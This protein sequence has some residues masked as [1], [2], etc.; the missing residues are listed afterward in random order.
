MT[1]IATFLKPVPVASTAL[2][3][4]VTGAWLAWSPVA[5][6]DT[7]AAQPP[8]VVDLVAK[9]SPAVV[10]VLATQEASAGDDQG[11]GRRGLAVRPGFA[12]R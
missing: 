8:S 10:T 1:R 7:Q 12:F 3:A 11:G 2:A 4:A 5:G 9:T 6:A